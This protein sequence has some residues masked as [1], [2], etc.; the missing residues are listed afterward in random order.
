MT[1]D[2]RTPTPQRVAVARVREPVLASAR[3]TKILH[4]SKGEHALA[5]CVSPASDLP[6]PFTALEGMEA[7]GGLL[8]LTSVVHFD[9]ARRLAPDA[10]EDPVPLIA[11]AR[12]LRFYLPVQPR[13]TF[14]VDATVIP[15][16]GELVV[17]TAEARLASGERVAK[18]ELRF[19]L[20]PGAGEHAATSR[21]QKALRESLGFGA[22]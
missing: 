18:G 5:E 19:L 10:R 6:R 4:W 12:S 3:L 7:L 22:W 15:E 9:Q 17:I 20:V 11:G 13:G 1:E 16:E 14:E 8:A 21:A 2:G